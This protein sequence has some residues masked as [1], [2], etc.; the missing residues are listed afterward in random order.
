[1]DVVSIKHG[2]RASG[3]FMFRLV[4]VNN[5]KYTIQVQK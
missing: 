1:M 5:K 2:V 3:H 4:D